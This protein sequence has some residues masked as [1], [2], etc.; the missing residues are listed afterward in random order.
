[1]SCDNQIST[2]DLINAKADA[3][4]LGEIATSHEGAVHSGA[5]ITQSTNRFGGVTDTVQGRLNKLGVILDDPIR[6]WSASLLVI[7]LRAHRYPAATGDVYIP[8]KPLPF[9]TGATF[10]ASDWVLLNGYAD[11]QIEIIST[12]TLIS[13]LS[14]TYE[15]E[16]LALLSASTKVFPLKKQLKTSV[17]SLITNA[18]GASYTVTAGTSPDSANPPLTTGLY[19]K[20]NIEY[21]MDVRQAGSTGAEPESIA[22][23]IAALYNAG[24][25][26][27]VI[28]NSTIQ[29]GTLSLPGAVLIGNNCR[30]T[31]GSFTD[32]KLEGV[33]HIYDVPTT[34]EKAA[35]PKISGA[36]TNK[37]VFRLADIAQAGDNTSVL[38]VVTKSSTGDGFI[39]HTYKNNEGDGSATSAG[40]NWALMRSVFVEPVFNAVILK[41]AP[42]AESVVLAELGGIEFAMTPSSKSNYML[43][44]DGTTTSNFLKAK[45][46]P[47]GEW[48]EYEVALAAGDE[49]SRAA[50]VAIYS[51]NVVST[52][53]KVEVGGILAFQGSATKKGTEK[54]IWT[55]P[56]ELTNS[57]ST[58]D[59][60]H[61]IRVTNIAGNPVYVV[62][63]NYYRLDEAPSPSTEFDSWKLWKDSLNP[64]INL[65]GASDYAIFDTDLDVFVG[66]FHGGE[67]N[68]A[69][70]FSFEGVKFDLTTFVPFDFKVAK[71][72]SIKQQTD[73]VGKLS[74]YITTNHTIDGVQNF[75]CSM[76]GNMNCT[77]LYTMLC[78][79]YREFDYILHP[80]RLL[81]G[82]AL[83]LQNLGDVQ[84]VVQWRESTDQFVHSAFTRFDLSS[85][86]R[87]GLYLDNKGGSPGVVSNRKV[88]YGPVYSNA[89]N[90]TKLNF[91]TEREF[92]K[93]KF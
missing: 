48:V 51:S 91:E 81:N 29:L 80:E 85:N 34:P 14:Q 31:S 86:S 68:V 88:Y 87:G 65:N 47:N 64:F 21:E 35:C 50:N 82:A 41:R 58:T 25:R 30:V 4:T 77:T 59:S 52:D 46:V 83:T 26:R 56:I 73:I 66:S 57:D 36:S 90:V 27:I 1:M 70:D 54:G 53:F 38:G 37:L 3:I 9:T 16:T 24:C 67:T 76:V 42:S 93:G 60:I 92:G 7:D 28:P 2:Q 23:P 8:V 44:S 89:L 33:T 40:A 12:K 39:H 15:F 78:P 22:R 32:C 45:N 20:I 5:L 69:L 11:S 71:T 63:V 13:D 55:I 61:T 49:S 75:K 62:G 43:N 74:T 18:G 17:N 19:A 10:N 6:D 72:I 79:T 84:E